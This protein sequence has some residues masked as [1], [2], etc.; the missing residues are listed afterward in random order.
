MM[1]GQ[2]MKQRMQGPPSRDAGSKAIDQQAAAQ[3]QMFAAFQMQ[4]Q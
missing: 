4:Q 1:Q 2:M 3:A